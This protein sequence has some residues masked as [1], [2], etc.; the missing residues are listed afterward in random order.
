MSA[1]YALLLRLMQFLIIHF[2]RVY[3][4]SWI[5]IQRAACTILRL[6]GGSA[7]SVRAVT[8]YTDTLYKASYRIPY[9][10]CTCGVILPYDI[11][12]TEFYSRCK[13]EMKLSMTPAPSHYVQCVK[14]EH[15]YSCTFFSSHF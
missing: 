6:S 1:F 12:K 7:K 11:F 13:V 14:M 2:S 15:S 4:F 3:N 9:A 8:L 10:I 5:L